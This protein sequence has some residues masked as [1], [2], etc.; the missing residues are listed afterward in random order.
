MP[1]P[2]DLPRARRAEPRTADGRPR[3]PGV[4][5]WARALL[6]GA[7]AAAPVVL[8]G[9][10]LVYEREQDKLARAANTRA[11]DLARGVRL[12]SELASL[13]L[14]QR[15][16]DLV[17]GGMPER[18][19]GEEAT[20]WAETSPAALRRGELIHAGVALSLRWRDRWAGLGLRDPA[21]L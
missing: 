9:G 3:R 16:R 1:P 18:Q 21:Q 19:A 14:D 6:A 20:R 5:A 7:M 2:D 8:G 15:R 10:Y 11:A 17:A 13:E 4:P 12:S